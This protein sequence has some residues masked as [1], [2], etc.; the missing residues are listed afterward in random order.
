MK[1]HIYEL[2][3][4]LD[5]EPGDIVCLLTDGFYEWACPDGEEFGQHRVTELLARCADQP[6]GRIIECI[7][8]GVLDFAHGTPQAD[9]LTAV[10]VKRDL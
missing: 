8:Q 3:V 9:D 6:A 4:T 1:G 5:L 10:L 2:A 7:Y